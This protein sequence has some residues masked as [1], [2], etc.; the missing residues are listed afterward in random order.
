[1]RPAFTETEHAAFAVA[2]LLVNKARARA[3]ESGVLCTIT[4]DD[5]T[6]PDFCPL[7]GIPLKRCVGG[8]PG[9]GSP[10]IDRIDPARGYVPGNVWVISH[11]ANRIKGDASAGELIR[12][13]KAL[14][15]LHPAAIT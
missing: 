13:G 14:R 11:R 3:R 2:R 6:I 5:L 4:A 7:L 1:M 10:S 9:P 8:S 12:I 15:N